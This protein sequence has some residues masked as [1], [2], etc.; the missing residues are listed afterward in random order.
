MKKDNYKF[1]GYA[2]LGIVLVVGAL[3]APNSSIFSKQKVESSA[4]GAYRLPDKNS[5]TSSLPPSVEWHEPS[6][7]EK[8][9]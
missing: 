3:I 1:V 5:Q 7:L 9:K 2:I 4:F 8:K 6:F